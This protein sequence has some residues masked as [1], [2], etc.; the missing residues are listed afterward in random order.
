MLSATWT[1]PRLPQ[2]CDLVAGLPTADLASALMERAHRYRTPNFPTPG[3]PD[4]SLIYPLW[5]VGSD[6]ASD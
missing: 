1:L 4:D 3:K 6:F 2:E 5:A